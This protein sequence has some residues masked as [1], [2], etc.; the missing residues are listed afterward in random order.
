IQY[1]IDLSNKIEDKQQKLINEQKAETLYN[2]AL[3]LYN[4]LNQDYDKIFNLLDK[5][6][7][8]YPKKVYKDFRGKIK[9]DRDVIV[10]EK[11][12]EEAKIC[13]SNN[14]FDKALSL[15]KE[16]IKLSPSNRIY[17]DLKQKIDWEQKE[18]QKRQEA[19]EFYKSAVE[20]YND[21]QFS[22]AIEY[23]EE[24]LDLQ[25]HN[26]T[27]QILLDKAE[28]GKIDIMTCTKN[29]LLTLDFIN[30]EQA[31]NIIQAR[32]NGITWYDYQKFAEQFNIMPHQWTEVEEKIIFPL[33]QAS[34]YGRKLDA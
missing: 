23:L 24:A 32:N 19:E 1:Y 12:Y 17:I 7:D 4:S 20:N 6:I 16:S 27:Y 11:F 33:K 5:A 3:S 8:L 31:E 29:A 13:F 18:F 30:E 2:E 9:H 22:E 21:G 34:R 26:E 15:V 10:A 28:E 14:D 25:P